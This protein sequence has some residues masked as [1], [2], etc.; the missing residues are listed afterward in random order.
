MLLFLI[1]FC[2][3]FIRLIAVEEVALREIVAFFVQFLHNDIDTAPVV[4]F[5]ER[6]KSTLLYAD[7]LLKLFF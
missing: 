4:V 7:I 1:A 2:G 3:K 6:F 5:T